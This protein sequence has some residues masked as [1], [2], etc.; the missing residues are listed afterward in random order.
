MM[1]SH[2]ATALTALCEAHLDLQVALIPEIPA[3]TVHD[4]K[5]YQGVSVPL[6][7]VITPLKH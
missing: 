4:L 2:K 3:T 7:D 5:S 1:F 6:S